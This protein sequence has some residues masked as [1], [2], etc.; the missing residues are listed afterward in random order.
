MAY[1]LKY[2][3]LCR[4]KKGNLYKAKVYF[5]GYVGNQIDRNVPIS[6]FKLRKDKADYIRGTSFEYSIIEEVDFEF[7]EFYT[8]KTKAIKVELY[9]PSDVLMWVGYNLPQQYSTPY[10]PVPNTVTFIATDGLGLLKNESFPLSGFMSLLQIIIYCISKTELVLG[11]SIAINLFATLH[12]HSR[13][14]LE[15]T[16]ISAE[17][18][19]GLTCYE[20]I[21]NI[22]KIFN[23]E[24]TQ[25]L[26]RWG[27]TRSSDVKS[28]RMLYSSG[29]AYQGTESAPAVL[30]LGYPGPGIEVSPVGSLQMSL[31]PGGKQVKVKKTI[32]LKDNL[33]LNSDFAQFSLLSDQMIYDPHFENWTQSGSGTVQQAFDNFGLPYALIPFTGL[34]IP[35]SL[36]QSLEVESVTGQAFSFAINV[37]TIYRNADGTPNAYNLEFKITVTITVGSTVWYL[38]NDVITLSNGKILK[39][40]LAVPAYI[41]L[42]LQASSSYLPEFSNVQIITDP[43]PGSGLLEIK[44][45]PPSEHHP[46]ITGE[47]YFVAYQGLRVNLATPNPSE[48]IAE[49]INSTEP[50]TL[51]DVELLITEGTDFG[52]AALLTTNCLCYQDGSPII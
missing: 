28:S 3:L 41:K 11:Y 32:K 33:F 7:L 27:I 19:S 39:G 5:D 45:E 37:G 1:G 8:N 29:G 26:G 24:I 48:V 22:L 25:R 23:A 14:P 15:Q 46:F 13:S 30:N 50:E 35:I 16:Y 34:P 4:S 31:V 36:S 6:P 17:T 40:W 38:T 47:S 51:P 18:F 21:E 12:D 20:V 49:F 9:G 2:E 10:T 52:N 44:L 42:N 43:L